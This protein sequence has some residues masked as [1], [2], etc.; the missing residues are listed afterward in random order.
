MPILSCRHVCSLSGDCSVREL[1]DFTNRQLRATVSTLRTTAAVLIGSFCL[2]CVLRR[3]SACRR[4]GN[5]T[6]SEYSPGA[7]LAPDLHTRYCQG[8][9]SAESRGHSTFQ[10]SKAI[11]GDSAGAIAAVAHC[12]LIVSLQCSDGRVL[13]SNQV[14]RHYL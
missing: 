11:I 12:L 9:H 8:L 1:L 7:R 13:T 10:L 6:S 5:A 3:R 4:A 2:R 14:A